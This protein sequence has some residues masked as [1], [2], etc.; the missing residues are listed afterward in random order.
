MI[1]FRPDGFLYVTNNGGSVL[2]YDAL[3]GGFGDVFIPAGTGGLQL[4]GGM[5]WDASGNFYVTSDQVISP[6][7]AVT[8]VLRFNGVTG[9]FIDEFVPHGSGGGNYGSFILFVPEP[10][11]AGVVIIIAFVCAARRNRS[12]RAPSN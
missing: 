11:L 5:A 4:P 2:R 3:T 12:E 7:E 1:R 6:T 10:H 9:A 8:G